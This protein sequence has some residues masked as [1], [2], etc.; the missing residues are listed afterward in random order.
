MLC[1]GGSKV[2]HNKEKLLILYKNR[3]LWKRTQE[4]S[5][6]L[7]ILPLNPR[8]PPESIALHTSTSGT[9]YAGNAYHITSKGDLIRYLHQRLF[10]PSKQKLIKSIQNNQIPKWPGLTAT[11]VDKYLLNGSP[12]TDKDHMK[13]K[14]KGI[15][16]TK[17]TLKEK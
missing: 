3:I 6:R 9:Q 13:R 15:R 8:T 2:S 11:A 14:I 10:C 5:T 7:W 4:L 12:S 16:T 17:Y 1:D